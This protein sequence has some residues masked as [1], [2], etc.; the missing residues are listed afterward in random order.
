M[1]LQAQTDF[2][3]R[4]PRLTAY[5]SGSACTSGWFLLNDLGI[6]YILH[7][8]LRGGG[9]VINISEYKNINNCHHFG[10]LGS[11][12]LEFKNNHQNLGNQYLLSTYEV[13]KVLLHCLLYFEKRGQG[14]GYES[15]PWD[16]C[17]VI[18][19]TWCSVARRERLSVLLGSV[20]NS[21][22]LF[23]RALLRFDLHT[24][25]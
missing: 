9:Q 23:L 14:T 13:S 2:S 1:V 7:K 11:H 12:Q 22:L 6:A 8:I 4:F 19:L 25:K 20:E 24:I 5:S 21:V 16:P 15:G 17:V 3:C 18:M 10:Y